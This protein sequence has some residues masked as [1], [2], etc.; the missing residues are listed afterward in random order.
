MSVGGT[1]QSYTVPSSYQP[2]ADQVTFQLNLPPPSSFFASFVVAISD[3]QGNGNSSRVLPIHTDGDSNSN[4][5]PWA[6]TAAFTY[7]GDSQVGQDTDRVQCGN[8]RYYP[9]SPPFRGTRPFS[10]TWVPLG[11][12]PISISIPQSATQND[13]FFVYT[14]PVPFASGTQV[15][16]FL[17]DATGG[18]SGGG[19]VVYT[20]TSSS[21]TSCLDSGYTLANQVTDRTMPLGTS[22]ATF[23]NLAG[24][25]DASSVTG[26]GNNTGKKSSE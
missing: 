18:G 7:A 15:Y 26:D 13:S 20:V 23:Q 16:Q 24:A 11:A 9:V 22:T 6:G 4:C 19:S 1:I 17:S 25:V 5:E 3:A 2:N 12:Q 8:V 10:I 14:S 21:D